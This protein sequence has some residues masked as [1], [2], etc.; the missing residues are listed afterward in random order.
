MNVKT[1]IKNIKLGAKPGC[2]VLTLLREGTP[3]ARGPAAG[4]WGILPVNY[5]QLMLNQ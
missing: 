1:D 5:F 4:L 3:L 2:F